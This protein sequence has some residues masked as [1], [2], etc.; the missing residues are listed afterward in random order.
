MA[1]SNTDKQTIAEIAAAA[2]A[3]A[4]S[5]PQPAAKSAATA[6]RKTATRKTRKTATAT[7][8]RKTRK[9]AIACITAGEAWI[10]LGADET[11]R[12]RD[13]SK[14]ANNAQLW[15]LNEAGLLTLAQ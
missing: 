3:A 15:K 12:P 2:V 1:L 9:T 6:T 10:A 8:A 7:A 11:Y 13:E 5:Q 4:L 14:P